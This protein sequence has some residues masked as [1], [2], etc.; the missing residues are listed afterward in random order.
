[1]PPHLSENHNFPEHIVFGHNKNAHKN[2]SPDL[3]IL[4]IFNWAI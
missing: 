4:S 2:Y 3:D 1:M